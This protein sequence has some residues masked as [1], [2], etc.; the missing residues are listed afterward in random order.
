MNTI[1]KKAPAGDDSYLEREYATSTNQETRIG[2]YER[3]STNPQ[4]WQRWVW[5]RLVEALAPDARILELGC[6]PGTLWF[7]NRE[8]IPPGWRVTLSDFSPGML[9]TARKTL[10]SCAH[11][12]AFEVIDIRRDDGPRETFDA[13]VANHM[14][15]HIEACAE[16]LGRIHGFLDDGGKLLA[17]TLGKSHLRELRT[18]ILPFVTLPPTP[19]FIL[20]TGAAELEPWFEPVVLHRYDNALVVPEAGPLVDYVVSH[21]QLQPGDRPAFVRRL[22][23]AVSEGPLHLTIDA[24][25]FEATRR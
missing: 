11:P 5:D 23:E 17:A 22:E 25:L 24:G 16:A 19:D 13:V 15:F 12:F 4:G 14:L 1:S 2:F 7:E 6:G 20:E 8:R 9:D 18:L 21:D 10:Q 3:H